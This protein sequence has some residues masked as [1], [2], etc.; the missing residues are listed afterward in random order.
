MR[1]ITWNYRGLENPQVVRALKKLIKNEVSDV[2]FLIE[3]KKK[4][5][6]IQFLKG[7]D[8]FN[9]YVVIDCQGGGKHRTGGLAI[10]GKNSIDVKV[11]SFSL[12]HINVSYHC[13]NHGGKPT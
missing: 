1:A 10:L 8:L 12:S 9:N 13:T 2:V 7:V 6:K 11:R 4:V 5:T 3:T